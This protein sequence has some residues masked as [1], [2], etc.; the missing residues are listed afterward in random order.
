MQEFE[1]EFKSSQDASLIPSDQ[2]EQFR[3]GLKG[4]PKPA[5]LNLSNNP[6]K[7]ITAYFWKEFDPTRVYSSSG[8]I[9]EGT[10]NDSSVINIWDVTSVKNIQL[11]ARMSCSKATLVDFGYASYELLK[12][13]GFPPFIVE[14]N[15]VGAGFVDI[16]LNT[17]HFP[18]HRMF[19]E[20]SISSTGK[21][22]DISYGVKSKNKTKLD[23]CMFVNE[24][25]TTPEIRISIPDELLV[26]E[27]GTFVKKNTSNS[28]TFAAKDKCHDDYM[29]TWIWGMYLLFADTIQQHYA[30]EKA[31]RTSM[32]RVLPD[33]IQYQIGLSEE[34]VKEILNSESHISVMS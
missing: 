19:Y 10:G 14:N 6:D 30:V 3:R 11:V 1:C 21:Y 18:K 13:Y 4:Y 23:A 8:D 20:Q 9:S 31:F 28:I 32:G 29:M 17:Y 7:D 22:G 2:L 15:G 27:M 25:V 5:E 12:M 34:E 26:N 16:M 24:L 33:K